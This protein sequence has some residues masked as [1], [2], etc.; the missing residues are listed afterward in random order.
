M[1]NDIFVAVIAGLGGMLGWGFADFFAKKTIDEI[2]DV[3]TLFWA[4]AIGILPLVGLFLSNPTLPDS[5]PN[6]PLFII[7]LG[8]FSGLSYLPLYVAFGKGKVSLISP[9][10]ASYSAVVALISWLVFHES[11]TL[12]QELAIGIVFVGILLASTNPK[13]LISILR[14]KSKHK[15]DGLPE[16]L[17]ALF[18]YSLWLVALDNFLSGRDWVPF[19]LGIRIFSSLALFLYVRLTQGSL[20][21]KNK[22]IWK[23]LIVIGVFDVAAF[24]SVSYGFSETTYTA[25]V[26]VLS[27]TF[28]IP[29]ILLARTFLKEKATA[30]Q[31]A[32]TII[33]LLGIALVTLTG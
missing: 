33:I 5:K 8:I 17:A 22:K 16:V 23:Y 31:T 20:R 29:T 2:G 7:L 3:T 28:S 19:L 6:D 14:S 10:F 15:I 13:E 9:I 12:T 27:A 30:L 11:L 25:I 32:A 26:T 21:I 4:Q 18:S 24:S 1:S